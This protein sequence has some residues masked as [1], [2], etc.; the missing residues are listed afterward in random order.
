M[1]LSTIRILEI[2]TRRSSIN[3]RKKK[4]M[5]AIITNKFRINNAD[6]FSESFF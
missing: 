4:I 2:E 6:Q 5:P 3:I 1:V